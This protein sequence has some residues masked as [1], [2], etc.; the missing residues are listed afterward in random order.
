MHF[1]I[2]SSWKKLCVKD[3]QLHSVVSWHIHIDLS[4]C[5][6]DK[7]FCINAIQSAACALSFYQVGTCLQ[8][9]SK[10]DVDR[11]PPQ[12]WT[13]CIPFTWLQLSL[14]TS[15]S[16]KICTWVCLK[17]EYWSTLNSHRLSLYMDINGIGA[18]HGPSSVFG[19][20][21]FRWRMSLIYI[22]IYTNIT[23]PNE[24]VEIAMCLKCH[25]KPQPITPVVCFSVLL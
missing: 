5:S 22:I 18:H 8:V 23:I 10:R 3:S 9:Q 25:W 1:G 16:M 15:L 19:H 24:V 11:V 7:G 2:N 13:F 21:K 14:G 6:L 4:I 12:S 17:F 20:I